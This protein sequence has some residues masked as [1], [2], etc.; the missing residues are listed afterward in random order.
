MT[1]RTLRDLPGVD[2]L[3]LKAVMKPRFADPDV[4]EGRDEID[5]LSTAL[6]GLSLEAADDTEKPTDW[7]RIER[8]SPS[9]MV[10]AFEAEGWDVTDK[11][12]KPLRLLPHLALP[13]ALA[14]RGVSGELPFLAEPDVK[15]TDWG[16]NLAA[17][18]SRFRKR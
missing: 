18:A 4:P 2:D 5:A 6:F 3:E 14:M 16:S 9:D 13:L 7:D 12:R 10:E 11:K 17:E 15:E 1:L 8:L